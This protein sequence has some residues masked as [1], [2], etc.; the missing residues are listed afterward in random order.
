MAILRWMGL[1]PLVVVLSGLLPL[2]VV[3]QEEWRP[4]TFREKTAAAVAILPEWAR[5]QLN[6]GYVVVIRRVDAYAGADLAAREIRVTDIM[7]H[8]S[9]EWY[10]SQL[11][12]ETYHL[13]ACASGDAPAGGVA[14]EAKATRYQ[15]IILQKLGRADLAAGLE[16]SIGVHGTEADYPIEWKSHCHP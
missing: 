6:Q 15:Q 4:P 8:S 5:F 12:H 7:W 11:V 1:T 16:A 9:L 13:W 10:A 2:G 3:G 14:G